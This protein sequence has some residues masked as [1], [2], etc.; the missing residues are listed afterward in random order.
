MTAFGQIMA[1]AHRALA[2][3]FGEAVV[4]RRAADSAALSRVLIGELTMPVIDSEGYT[5]Q[6]R[7][8]EFVAQAA[9]LL[10]GGLLATPQEGDL[11]ERS[12]PLGL[13]RFEVCRSPAEDRC[14]LVDSE[15]VQFRIFAREKKAS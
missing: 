12:T 10:L 8:L 7:A 3:V 2:P 4:Y 14:Y 1:E 9:E 11:I 13:V 15:R 5:V 6:W